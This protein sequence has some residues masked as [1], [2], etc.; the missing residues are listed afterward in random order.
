[1]PDL[2]DKP[3]E[4]HGLGLVGVT[5]S[6]SG[7]DHVFSKCISCEGNDWNMCGFPGDPDPPCRF[8][9]T[10]TRKAQ[11]HYDQMRN[12]LSRRLDARQPVFGKKHV[13]TL[14][15]Q[16]SGHKCLVDWLI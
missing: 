5:A 6:L 4:N 11:I 13:I 3:F 9:S 16:K 2:R 1:M 10:N 7:F 12:L 14:V 15:S 8:K